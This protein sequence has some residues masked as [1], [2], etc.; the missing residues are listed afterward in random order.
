MDDVILVLCEIRDT[1]TQWGRYSPPL[2]LGMFL[3]TLCIFSEKNKTVFLLIVLL[4]SH[5]K[6]YTWYNN[7]LEVLGEWPTL[8]PTAFAFL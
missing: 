7:Q 1:G 2:G 8:R 6:V 4:P 5:E 3:C